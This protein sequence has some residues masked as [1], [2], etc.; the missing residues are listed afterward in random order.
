MSYRPWIVGA[1]VAFVTGSTI[2]GMLDVVPPL[3]GLCGL[4]WGIVVWTAVSYP[5]EF[6]V[7]FRGVDG[8]DRW[9]AGMSRLLIACAFA[10]VRVIPINSQ[11]AIAL[12]AEI[13][14]VSI[15]LATLGAL[16]ETYN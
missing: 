6:S 16:I 3:A 9:L 4:V 8:Q 12:Y 5:E 7:S 1:A 14:G 15:G 13:L 11:T 2:V 10:P